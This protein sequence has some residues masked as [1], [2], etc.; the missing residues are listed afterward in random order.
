M[1]SHGWMN[2]YE[3]ASLHQQLSA[4]YDGS[5][6]LTFYFCSFLQIVAIMTSKEQLCLF[7]NEGLEVQ[8]VTIESDDTKKSLDLSYHTHL[9]NTFGNPEKTFYSS[10][11][12]RAATVYLLGSQRIY[13]ARLLPWHDQLKALQ[14]AGDWMGAFHVGM[15]L[16]DGRALS[17]MGLPRELG[18]LQKAVT[19][20]LL[21]VLSAYI[22]EVFTYLSLA[23][24]TTIDAA[25][26]AVDKELMAQAKEQY[27]RVGG[28][29]IEFCVHIHQMDVLFDN[30]FHKFCTAG[31]R[32]NAVMLISNV[33]NLKNY[34]AIC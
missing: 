3:C 12:V 27:A 15:E 6:V 4:S 20:T 13:R 30:I 28:V 32:G 10:L 2:R 25:D 21:D 23:F 18:S 1:G 29:A 14:D 19:P 17:V 11:A 5:G 9:L 8:R 22:D 16:F 26:D 31:Q 33:E 24:G 34:L 7:T